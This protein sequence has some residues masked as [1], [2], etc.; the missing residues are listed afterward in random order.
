[1]ML[2]HTILDIAVSSS[3][4]FPLTGSSSHEEET[5][6]QLLRHCKN[7]LHAFEIQS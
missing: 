3:W 7:M 5:I 2:N 1:M 6:V 4:S